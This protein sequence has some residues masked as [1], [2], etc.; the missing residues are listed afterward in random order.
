MLL[1]NCI[2]PS[3][4]CTLLG[5]AFPWKQNGYSS[6]VALLQAI[7]E[8]VR[9]DSHPSEPECKLYGIGSRDMFMPSWV[10]KAQGELVE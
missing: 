3:L 9:F 6:A 10:I 8:A 2:S 5:S 4:S 1:P 7:P